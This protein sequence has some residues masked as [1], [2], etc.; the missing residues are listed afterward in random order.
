MGAALG[1]G[2]GGLV[3][4]VQSDV[5]GGPRG[6]GG[7]A[8]GDGHGGGRHGSLGHGAGR[9]GSGPELE[10]HLPKDV[11]PLLGHG[12]APFPLPYTSPQPL[13]SSSSSSP[14]SL[15]QVHAVQ[16]AQ[17]VGEHLSSPGPRHGAGLSRGALGAGLVRRSAGGGHGVTPLVHLRRRFLRGGVGGSDSGGGGGGWRGHAARVHPVRVLVHQGLGGDA[18]GQ[19][20]E[21]VAVLGGVH[22]ENVGLQ[23]LLAVGA[24]AAHLA[25]ELLLLPAP[26]P[27]PLQLSAGG[28]RRAAAGA[29]PFVPHAG[30]RAPHG[31][32]GDE[33]RGRVHAVGHHGPVGG[34][35]HHPAVQ[36]GVQPRHGAWG[37]GGG[38]HGEEGGHETPIPTRPVLVLAQTPRPPRGPPFGQQTQPRDLRVDALRQAAV[39]V[40]DGGGLVV[41]LA[42]VQLEAVAVLGGVGAVGAAVLVDVGVRL[43]V[44]VEHGFVDARVVALAALVGL[45]AEVVAEVVLQVVL[46]LRHEGAARASQQLLLLDVRPRMR[47]ERHLHTAKGQRV[48][49]EEVSSGQTVST[50]VTKGD[51]PVPRGTSLVT[52]E[53]FRR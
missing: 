35:G 29:L 28:G 52:D 13:P 23:R 48:V 30:G 20:V 38:G 50:Y 7:D 51:G 4:Q 44:R 37:V 14:S 39:A 32:D 9:R 27:R 6:H 25:Q 3:G 26:Q 40:E 10:R 43:H 21:Q 46:V 17:G 12:L 42:Q 33:G 31:P 5:L 8:G 19:H 53:R 2:E 45:G 1:R 36:H 18:E 47:P 49:R 16:V 24:E 11:R 34:R 15:A 41:V 22:L